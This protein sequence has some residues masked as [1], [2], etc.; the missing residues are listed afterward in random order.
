M[1]E[2]HRREAERIK[3]STQRAKNKAILA[4]TYNYTP[5][6]LAK[7]FLDKMAEPSLDE[8]YEN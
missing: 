2:D 5:L 3:K 7:Q 6:E 8:L 4:G 1:D